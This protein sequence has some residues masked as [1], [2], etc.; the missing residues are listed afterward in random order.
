MRPGSN[1]LGGNFAL[2]GVPSVGASGAI[3]GTTAVSQPT[4]LGNQTADCTLQVAWIDLFAHWRYQ[5]QPMKKVRRYA[6]NIE[7]PLTIFSIV[8]ARLDG[9]G[10][11]HRYRP[12]LHPM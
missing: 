4:N 2:V 12:G 6:T 5:Y 9:R 7:L 1:V 10:A 11:D 8:V 3:F